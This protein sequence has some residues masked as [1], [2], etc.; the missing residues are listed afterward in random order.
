MPA[1]KSRQAGGTGRQS[2]ATKKA[3]K[4]ENRSGK[5]TGNQQKRVV[6]PFDVWLLGTFDLSYTDAEADSEFETVAE[7]LDP[8]TL[9]SIARLNKSMHL[10]FTSKST[11]K[12][13]WK[14]VLKPLGLPE[15]E[16]DDMLGPA[17][18]ALLY[19][20]ICAVCGKG[21]AEQMS[22]TLRFR[23]HEVSISLRLLPSNLR[24]FPSSIQ[25]CEIKSV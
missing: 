5:D 12:S 4:G 25:E 14:K 19:E 23:W 10:F 2:T 22:F 8:P 6:L 7:K 17:L 13:I 16:N 24:S 3:R 9:L 20:R 18:V 21:G 15:L 11:S 1:S